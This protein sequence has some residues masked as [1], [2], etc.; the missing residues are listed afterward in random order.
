[1]TLAD[2]EFLARFEDCSLDDAVFK[3]TGHVRM[4]FL[5]LQ[6]HDTE[7]ALTRICKGIQRF[8]ASRGAPEKYHATVTIAFARII[9]KRLQ[10][11][12]GFDDFVAAN[13]DL[14]SPRPLLLDYYSEALL[15]SDEARLRFV[16]PDRRPLPT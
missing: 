14:M 2:D 1:M 4:A 13:P 10:P 12:Q 3:H 11:D 15:Y 9:A 16:A 6:R 7:T 8:G 5:Y